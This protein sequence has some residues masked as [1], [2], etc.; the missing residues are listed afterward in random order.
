M[1]NQYYLIFFFYRKV[2]AEPT[3]RFAK[4]TEH[5]FSPTRGSEKAAGLDLRRF[6]PQSFFFIYPLF[7]IQCIFN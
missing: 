2:E 4:L 5:A 6:V 3:M 7:S 1:I